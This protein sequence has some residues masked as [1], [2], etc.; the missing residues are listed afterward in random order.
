MAKLF[1][2][3]IDCTTIGRA[4][5][6][7]EEFVAFGIGHVY[8]LIHDDF[9]YSKFSV[10]QKVIGTI[11]NKNKFYVC[12]EIKLKSGKNYFGY[13][14]KKNNYLKL[15][16]VLNFKKE[17]YSHFENVDYLFGKEIKINPNE[18]SDLNF[19]IG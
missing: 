19:K 10:G 8:F 1:K 5:I 17:S 6:K 7:S 13:F 15:F 9:M 11:I 16:P 2:G 4:G 14:L 12:S 18:I 3:I